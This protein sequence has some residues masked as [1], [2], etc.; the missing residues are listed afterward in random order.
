M[1]FRLFSVENEGAASAFLQQEFPRLGGK[2]VAF[3]PL[4]VK[5]Q[6]SAGQSAEALVLISDPDRPGTVY[7]SSFETME[8][9][10]SF[11]SFET[12]NGLDPDLITTYWGVPK[13]IDAMTQ[14]QFS[15]ENVRAAAV[16]SRRSR[17]S[18]WLPPAVA[19]ASTRMPAAARCRPRATGCPCAPGCACA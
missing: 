6:A 18:P 17:R 7:L 12:E 1:S 10:E 19:R 2:S 15:S 16:A 8:D 5:P 14:N 3:W 4:K 9:A 13:T 11:M